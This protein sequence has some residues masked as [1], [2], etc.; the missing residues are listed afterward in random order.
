MTKKKVVNISKTTKILLQDV[1]G[2]L[3]ALGFFLHIY[4]STVLLALLLLWWLLLFWIKTKPVPESGWVRWVWVANH[5]MVIFFLISVEVFL[6]VYMV[7][8]LMVD[9]LVWNV[10]K[11]VGKK[12]ASN[13]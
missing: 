5:F 3:V 13:V 2:I 11:A 12:D 7:I 4:K 8:S 6:L 10:N 1:V 9:V